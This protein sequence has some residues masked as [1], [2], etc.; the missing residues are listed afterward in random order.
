LI[1]NIALKEYHAVGTNSY[2][3]NSLDQFN[4]TYYKA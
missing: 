1:H 2:I 4:Y 3:T